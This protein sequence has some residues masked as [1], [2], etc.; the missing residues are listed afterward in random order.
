MAEQYIDETWRA[1]KG[2][3]GYEVSDH[4]RVRS[5]RSNGPGEVVRSSPRLMSPS[6]KNN[7]YLQVNLWREGERCTISVHRLVLC[8]F[9]R[10][11]TP[12]EEARHLDGAKQNNKVAN[13]AWGNHATNMLDCVDHGTH[14]SFS[15]RGEKFAKRPKGHYTPEARAQ[16]KREAL[17]AGR[18]LGSTSKLTSSDVIEIRR[19][20]GVMPMRRIGEKYGICVQSVHSIIR[21]KTW[22]HV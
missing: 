13:L 19:L 8:T 7:G 1:V 21:K 12:E 2:Y 9:V 15:R 5:W 11:P 3:P 18:S 17:S 4:G 16:R 6:L 10:E 14:P 22:K 20:E